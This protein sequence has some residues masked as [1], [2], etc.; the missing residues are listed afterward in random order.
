MKESEELNR[1]ISL[2]LKVSS[3]LSMFLMAVG[4]VLFLSKPEQMSSRTGEV[5]F[6]EVLAGALQLEPLEMM[7]LG[8]IILISTPF[9]RVAGAFFSFLFIE[10]DK[11]FGFVALGVLAVL[12]FGLFI[13]GLTH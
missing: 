13:P 1:V 6:R 7:T 9:L 11:V 5:P 4:L 2:V 12:V 10:R 3:G 8:I